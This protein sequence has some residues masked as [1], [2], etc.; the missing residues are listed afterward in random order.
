MQAHP[1]PLEGV[2]G[3]RRGS[4]EDGWTAPGPSRDGSALDGPDGKKLA[5]APDVKIGLPQARLRVKYDE[6]KLAELLEALE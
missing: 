3:L 5:P 4:A 6:E 2:G 1:V